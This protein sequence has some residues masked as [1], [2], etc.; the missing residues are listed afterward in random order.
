[1]HAFITRFSSPFS[2]GGHVGQWLQCTLHNT[3]VMGLI[4][5]MHA[6]NFFWLV[7]DFSA[8]FLVT[9]LFQLAGVLVSPFVLLWNL[10]G[11]HAF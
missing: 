7:T 3:K 9:V 4:S 10:F 1:M 8:T 2:C 11:M 5:E 6:L